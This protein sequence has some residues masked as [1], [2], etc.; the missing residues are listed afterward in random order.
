VRV[1]AGGLGSVGVAVMTKLLGLLVEMVF[2]VAAGAL[3]AV[4][5]V[6]VAVL[7]R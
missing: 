3:L 6:G 4:V 5:V 7:F 1:L 2:G